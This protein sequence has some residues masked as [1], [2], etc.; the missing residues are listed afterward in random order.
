MRCGTGNRGLDV[1]IRRRH[2]LQGRVRIGRGTHDPFLASWVTVLVVTAMA[3]TMRS[4]RPPVPRQRIVGLDINGVR[5]KHLTQE[6]SVSGILQE[7]GIALGNRDR[8]E[9]ASSEADRRD[10]S[11][12]RLAIARHVTVRDEGTTTEVE[13]HADTVGEVLAG[14]GVVVGDYDQLFL[15]GNPCLPDTP[16]PP[17][18]EVDASSVDAIVSAFRQPIQVSVQRAVQVHVLDGSVL[19]TIQTTRNTVGEA[20]ADHNISLHSRDLVVPDLNATL[21]SETQVRIRRAT[22]VTLE[23]DRQV[24][25]LRTQMETV[26]ALL[27]SEG[28]VLGAMDYVV[29]G[30]DAPIMNGSRVVVVRVLD[31]YY[32]EETPIPFEARNETDPELE[33]DQYRIVRWGQEGARRRR[34]RI[35]Y[36]NE[37]E[38]SRIEEDSWISRE[39]LDRVI[40]YG[41]RIVVRQVDTPSGPQSYWRKLR[42]LATSYNAPTAGKSFDHPTYGITRV[43]WRAKKGIIAVDPRVINLKQGMYVPGYGVGVAADTGSAI[44][45]RR[46]DLCFDDDN[47]ELWRRWVDVY[48]MLPAPAE[49]EIAWIIPNWPQES[50]P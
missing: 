36:E 44:L 1:V 19:T 49:E 28:I 20:L 10:G 29:P 47:L 46:I 9:E 7:L 4:A 5:A 45:W 31:E 23:V 38:V 3:I 12:L 50:D 40:R 34:V 33:L 35:R 25:M 6:R 18:R 39:P 21:A 15:S 16:L 42:M 14:A 43:G 32:V 11:T 26:E 22:P 48:L 8:I 30:L 24:R 2:R 13:T 17:P 37:K 27:V 41:S